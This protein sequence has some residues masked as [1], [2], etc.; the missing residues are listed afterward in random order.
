MIPFLFDEGKW[1]ENSQYI[2]QIIDAIIDSITSDSIPRYKKAIQ[3]LGKISSHV[4]YSKGSELSSLI[5]SKVPIILE[6]WIKR[7]SRKS[8][9]KKEDSNLQLKMVKMQTFFAAFDEDLILEIC[10]IILDLLNGNSFNLTDI[11]FHAAFI[12]IRTI[13]DVQSEI[14][15]PFLMP[16]LKEKYEKAIDVKTK[17]WLFAYLG[18]F[19]SCSYLFSQMNDITKMI[20]NLIESKDPKLVKR[21]L[22]LVDSLC[23]S[24]M[25]PTLKNSSLVNDD[26]KNSNDFKIDSSQFFG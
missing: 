21:A 24:L 12:V 14:V 26:I 7:E 9:K 3:L 25:I 2:P 5:M 8:E 18:S 19:V 23:H 22:Y 1:Q 11:S 15:V 13:C 6:Q 17:F 20:I 4:Y 10:K 16:K